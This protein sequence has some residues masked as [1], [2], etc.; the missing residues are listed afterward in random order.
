M[1]LEIFRLSCETIKGGV[2]LNVDTEVPGVV[3]PSD[4]S[5]PERRV[6]W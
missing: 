5:P 2:M 6:T 3:A 4:A 1:S